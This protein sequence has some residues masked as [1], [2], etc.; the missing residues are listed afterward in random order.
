M[1]MADK[2]DLEIA[3]GKLEADLTSFCLADGRYFV[4]FK[5]QSGLY[6]LPSEKLSL[7]VRTEL[8]KQSIDLPLPTYLKEFELRLKAAA[9]SKDGCG[10]EAFCR[11]ARKND[12]IYL[13]LGGP[14]TR[15]VEIDRKGW[16]II[17]APP[18]LFLHPPGMLALPTPVKGGD[19][20]ELRQFIHVRE[21]HFP[22]LL[23]WQVVALSGRGPYPVLVMD[24]HNGSGDS[25]GARI[26]RMLI[27]PHEFGLSSPPKNEAELVNYAQNA[28]VVALDNVSTMRP[29]MSAAVCRLSTGCSFTRWG[30]TSQREQ[31]TATVETPVILNGNRDFILGTNLADRALFIELER[32]GMYLPRHDL[33]QQF[34]KAHPRLLGALLDGVS[35]GLRNE[36]KISSCHS[37]MAD[38]ERFARASETAYWP[39][40]TFMKAFKQNQFESAQDA[41]EANPVLQGLSTLVQAEGRFEGTPTQLLE[42]L[43][44]F[45]PAGS[46]AHSWPLTPEGLGKMLHRA[47]P[48]L[49][50]MELV[51]WRTRRA[52]GNR[53][54]I[55]HIEMLASEAQTATP[56]ETK[57]VI[58]QPLGRHT[59]EALSLFAALEIPSGARGL[60]FTETVEAVRTRGTDGTVAN[61]LEHS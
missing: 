26:V 37:P 42:K 32:P 59:V 4:K 45:R 15:A 61:D 46:S 8:R 33:I 39:P 36:H 23:A 6:D 30:N 22:L 44:I 16:K 5:D 7:R 38:F 53:D 10:E 60:G 57:S 14:T 17:E 52:G 3:L 20:D 34:G 21:H 25:T 56:P 41:M 29:A 27:D 55:I 51:M 35:E 28:H 2:A 47:A 31:R 13:D 11:V 54:R 40:D 58:P 1:N 48:D 24:D 19:I 12:K 9:Q 49:R 18:V 43:Q 50:K